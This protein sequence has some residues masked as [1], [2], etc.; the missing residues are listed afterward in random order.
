MQKVKLVKGE[1]SGRESINLATAFHSP[2]FPFRLVSLHRRPVSL[3]LIRFLNSTSLN[4]FPLLVACCLALSAAVVAQDNA[5]KDYAYYA[6]QSAAAYEKKDYAAF[7]DHARNARELLPHAPNSLFR[8][9]RAHALAGDANE[10]LRMLEKAVVMGGGLNAAAHPDFASIKNSD[11]FKSILAKIEEARKP[12]NNSSIAFIIPEKDILP[13]SVA[14][15]PVKD[16][17]YVGSTYRRKVVS[18]DRRG[19]YKDFVAEKQDGQW[20][21]VGMKVD[22]KR[23]ELWFC[24]TL[25]GAMK[26]FKPEEVGRRAGV[27]KYNL[28]TGK[29]VKKYLLENPAERHF[30]NDLVVTAD[31]DVYLTDMF[32]AAL[33]TI[34]RKKDE[35][36]PFAR[37]ENFTDPN[38]IALSSD[39]QYFFVA[40]DEGISRFEIKTRARQQLLHPDDVTLWGIDGLYF[41]RNQLIAVQNAL[42]RVRRFRLDAGLGRV[43]EAQTIE[44]NHPFFTMNP[45]TGVIVGDIFY[46]I[47]NSQFGSFN[48]D[49]TL[50]PPERLYD[51]VILKTKL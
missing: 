6:A 26:D 46:Y 34:K 47:A 17:F 9:A 16:L 18:V 1:T 7:L 35:L 30:F 33:Y 4:R 29:L 28:D 20:M 44:A 36:E 27:F 5:K 40:H 23:R 10:S 45:T 12:V 3:R 39:G 49:N 19:N 25:A 42:N 41:Y 48:P 22:A 37:P 2:S 51:V 50:F 13:E 11:G 43:V 15:D 31:G 24:S 14:Y 32:G 8:L 21:V 38:G